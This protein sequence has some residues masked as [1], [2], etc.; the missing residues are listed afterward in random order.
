V[1]VWAP[2]RVN[3]IGEHTDY[4]GGLVLPAATQLGLTFDFDA[5][6]DNRVNLVSAGFDAGEPFSAD[7]GGPQA[8]GW[9]RYG[10]AV[11]AE[12][13]DLGRPPI[14]IEAS[15]A[16]TLPAG[17][18]LSSSAALE[19]GV[20][21]C[22]CAVADFAVPPLELAAACQRAEARAVGVP[23]GILDPAACLLGQENTAILLN[24][25]T[26]EYEPISIPGD[27]AFLV[28]DSGVER[29]LANTGY[30]RR[31][32]ELESALASAGA[33]NSL[34]LHTVDYS[35]VDPLSRRRLRHVRT[36]NERVTRF[37]A[38]LSANDLEAAGDILIES[39]D[40]LRDDY[41]VSTPELDELV[42]CACRSG[43]YGARLVGGGFGGAVLALVHHELASRVGDAIAHA[44][45]DMAP[46]FLI[47]AS[48]GAQAFAPG[49]H[50]TA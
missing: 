2:G 23:C 26:L 29:R 9:T 33:E 14:G 20:A 30:A 31:R 17:A 25:T 27:A 49:P 8:Q 21:L 37:A 41:D 35:R 18:G 5:R 48:A 3:L 42:D 22:L 24:C 16:S 15:I 43:A 47:Q 44:R 34:E 45:R 28:L 12:L 7:G 32:Q 36:E 39:H 40:S 4:S 50:V 19:V 13:A 11:A 10:Q 1:R 6:N 38:A 46:P